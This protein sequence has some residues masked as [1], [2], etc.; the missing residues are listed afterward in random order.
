MY[1]VTLHLLNSAQFQMQNIF[2]CTLSHTST[3]CS[4]IKI[5]I[6]IR[7]ADAVIKSVKLFESNKNA[8]K[9]TKLLQTI[10]GTF[11]RYHA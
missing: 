7:S 9:V 6:S 10:A 2:R 1:T 8:V 3:R 4:E 11:R 5:N